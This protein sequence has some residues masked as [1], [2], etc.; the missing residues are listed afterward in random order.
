MKLASHV[1]LVLTVRMDTAIPPLLHMPSCHAQGQFYPYL[2][3]KKKY[4]TGQTAHVHMYTLSRTSLN[5]F[6]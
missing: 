4:Y 5:R 6:Q 2:S 1:H 3:E